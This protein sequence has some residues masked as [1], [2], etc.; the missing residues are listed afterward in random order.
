MRTTG[1]TLLLTASCWGNAAFGTWLMNPARST[2]SRDAHPKSITIRI[3]LHPKGEV[4]TLDRI[5]ADGRTTTS[6]TLL[7]LDG[8]PRD[9]Q[10][11]DCSGSQSSRRLDGQTVEIVRACANGDRIRLVRRLSAQPNELFL[12][13]TE[14]QA[15]GTTLEG[16][17][18]LEK[19]SAGTETTQKK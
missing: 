17:L 4:F 13:I 14:Q 11:A 2:F 6:S 8:E 19:Q 12:E 3:E 16:R 7:Y 18:V 1:L 9:F 10:D 15:G 5:E